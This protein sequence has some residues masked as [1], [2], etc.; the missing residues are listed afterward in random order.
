MFQRL[1]VVC[2]HQRLLAHE[3]NLG[4]GFAYAGKTLKGASVTEAQRGASLLLRVSEDD[5]IRAQLGHGLHVLQLHLLASWHIP[6][7]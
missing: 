5:D 6:G 7:C 3:S 1:N 2:M 4:I